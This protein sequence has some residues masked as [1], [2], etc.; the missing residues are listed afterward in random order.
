MAQQVEQLIRNQQVAGSN[1]ATSSKK[2]V[3]S[4][5]DVAIFLLTDSHEPWVPADYFFGVPAKQYCF[6]G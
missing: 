3:T 6:V 5:N 4:Q 2:M 1:P